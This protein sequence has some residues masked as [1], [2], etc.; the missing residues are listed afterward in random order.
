M[1]GCTLHFTSIKVNILYPPLPNWVREQPALGLASHYLVIW[2]LKMRNW[3]V[4]IFLFWKTEAADCSTAVICRLTLRQKC[5]YT[6]VCPDSE[7]NVRLS[8]CLFLTGGWLE[9]DKLTQT[10]ERRLTGWRLSQTVPEYPLLLSRNLYK[11]TIQPLIKMEEQSGVAREEM[12]A[13]DRQ[14]EIFWPN[15]YKKH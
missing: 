4:E 3:I 8:D 14:D 6:H 5:K 7:Q 15:L 13:C 12:K 2:R 11:A 9:D 1:F 10:E